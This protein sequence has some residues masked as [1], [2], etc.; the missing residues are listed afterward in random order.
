M[1][2]QSLMHVRTGRD[3]VISRRTFLRQAA[4]GAGGLSL[5]GWK[6]AVTLQARELRKQGMACV[7]LFMRGGPSQFE[8]FDP[9]PGAKTGGPTKAIQTAVEGVQIAEGWT[10]LAKEMK[11]VALIRSLTSREG[12]HQRAAY[13]LHTGYAPTANVKY[14]SLG[15][16]VARELG[17]PDFDLANFVS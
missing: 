6:E 14:P 7:L 15:S 10:N 4:V 5:I 9:K 11:D 3:G 8:T 16:I 1:T 13:Q 17:K 2:L 12:E